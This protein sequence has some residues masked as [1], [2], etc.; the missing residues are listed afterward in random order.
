MDHDAPHK[1]SEDQHSERHPG[2]PTDDAAHGEHADHAAHDEHA[3]H[4]SHD[5][6][7]DRAGHHER[8][9]RADHAA[10]DEHEGHDK[11]EGHSPEMFRDRLLVSLLLTGPILYFSPQI[12][13]WFG[14]EAISFPGSDLVAPVLATVLFFYG[15][16][17]FLKGAISE[18]RYRQPGMMT[19][20]TLAITTSYSFSIAVTLGF[21][22]DDFYWELATL[23]DVM[24]LGH[25]IEMRSVVAASSALDQLAEMVPDMAHLAEADGSIV[26]VPVADLE[27]GQ[28]FV[29]RPGEQV[30]VDGE[31][32][33]GRSS[34]NEAFLTGE[35]RPVEKRLGDEV[36]SGAINGE[37]VLTAAVTRTG[38]ATTLSQIMR[39]VADAQASRSGYQELGDRA[40]FWLTIV[41]IGVAVPTLLIWLGLGGTSN[42][43]ITRTVTVLVIACPH[44][45]GL[46]IPLVTYNA[47]AM[48]ANN[49]VL[50]RNRDAF[51]RGSDIAIV[52]FDKTGTLTQG[53]FAL[54]SID[55][56][57]ITEGEA[58]A[59]GASLE[60]GSEHPLADVIV[61]AAADRDMNVSPATETKAIPGS[62]LEGVVAGEAYRVGRPEWAD[63]VGVA[64]SPVL[65][66]ALARADDRG[67][68]AVVLMNHRSVVAVFAMADQIRGGAN[69]AIASLVEM[70]VSPVMITGDA[71]AVARTVAGDLGIDR[72]YS[73]VLPG[74]KAKIVQDLQE[75]GKVAFVGDGIN[76]APSLLVADLGIAIGAG[77]NVAIES[78]DLVLVDDDPTDVP[79]ALRLSRITR[80]KMTQNLVWATGYNLIA[81]P[82]AAGVA[83]TAGIIVNPAIGA[84]FM[85]ASTVIVSL[86]AMAMRRKSLG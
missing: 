45:L 19:L 22:G 53:Q 81:I 68:T 11:H 54:T 6:H 3:D 57:G 36:V 35:S 8:A 34:M 80:S 26:D 84:L 64:S 33:E 41:A 4:A 14:Y 59:V 23:I 67:D 62:G 79:R 82:L 12:Q 72:Y 66:A 30:P 16:A 40:A 15:G 24:L 77:T 44:A 47:T 52:A 1:H 21:P 51:E 48:A 37:G 50:V 25:W 43:A 39:L 86:N 61:A 74:E 63:E 38:D 70:G 69:R 27:V 71:E 85:S 56:D 9:E 83:V 10:H 73:R 65:S 28:R 42:F 55:V 32:V 29:I 17:P 13:D 46:A 60:R 20:I 49:G 76:D 31:V 18:W 7:E 58:L 2:L 5:E 75:E 78:A